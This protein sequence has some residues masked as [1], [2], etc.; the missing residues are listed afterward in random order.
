MGK[1][2][3]ALEKVV[4]GAGFSIFHTYTLLFNLNLGFYCETFELDYLMRG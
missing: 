4:F 2:K 3:W 1:G